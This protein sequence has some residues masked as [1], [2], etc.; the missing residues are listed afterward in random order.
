MN[1]HFMNN[2]T[3]DEIIAEAKRYKQ[4]QQENVV[5]FLVKIAYQRGYTAGCAA[6]SESLNNER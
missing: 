4:I 5:H 2:Q 1:T 6:M 3:F